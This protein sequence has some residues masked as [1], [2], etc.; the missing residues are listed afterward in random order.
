MVCSPNMELELKQLS[1]C[2]EHLAIAAGAR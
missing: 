1:E 2:P